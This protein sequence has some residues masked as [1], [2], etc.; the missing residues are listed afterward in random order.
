M[1]NQLPTKLSRLPFSQL[2]YR[3]E[4]STKRNRDPYSRIIIIAVMAKKIVDI[5]LTVA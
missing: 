4:R 1:E 2:C 5:K 3:N